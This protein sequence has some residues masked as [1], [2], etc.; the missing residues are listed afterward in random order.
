[1]ATLVCSCRNVISDLERGARVGYQARMNE[2]LA[3]HVLAPDAV[4]ADEH[5]AVQLPVARHAERIV[6]ET[7]TQLGQ[8]LGEVRTGW[9]E[10]IDSCAG[11]EQLRAEVAAIENGAAHRLS[12]VCDELRETMTVQFVRLVLEL[13]R[14]LRQELLRKRLEVA[15]GRSPKTEETFE[16]IRLAFPASLDKAFAALRTPDIGEL[17]TIERSLF[18]PLFRTLGRERRDCLARL[19]AR[20]DDVARTTA[21]E[22]YASTVFVSPL[23]QTTFSR[24]IEE[25][26][27]AHERWI[28]ARAS[29][30]RQASAE[31][32]SRLT[33]ALELVDPLV[34]REKGLARLLESC[35]DGDVAGHA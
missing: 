21:R 25:L 30:E 1:V 5:A 9:A 34:E 2:L 24:L 35:G 28:E 7:A 26:L 10:R 13:S 11:I 8:K 14:P 12:L 6:Q 4:R 31:Q 20:L 29:E 32:R 27:A 33:P 22:L 3:R 15:R 23:L 18:D 16:D 19:R 17:L